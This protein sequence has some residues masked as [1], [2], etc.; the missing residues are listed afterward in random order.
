MYHKVFGEVRS[1]LQPHLRCDGR[2]GLRIC[3][4]DA[5]PVSASSV[6]AGLKHYS[7]D[8]ATT[9]VIEHN[10]RWAAG[11]VNKP[12]FQFAYLMLPTLCNQACRGCF[13][14]QD[15]HLLPDR[16]KGPYFGPEE[17]QS[18]VDFLRQHGAKALVYGGGGELFTWAGAFDLV[19]HVAACGLAMVIFTNG[20]LLT[21]QTIER[22]NE[23][24]VSII[25]SLRDTVET[26]HNTAVGRSHFRA[27]LQTIDDALAVGFQ[28]DSRLAVEIPVTTDNEDRVIDDF[29][30]VMRS[31]GVVPMIEEYIQLT[32]SSEEQRWCHNFA[33]S[34]R[35]FER[36]CAKDRSLGVCWEPEYGQRMVAQPRCQR[37]LYSFAVFPSRDVVDC[38]SHTVCYGNLRQTTLRDIVYSDKFRQSLLHYRL[39]PCSVFYTGTHS[40][41]PPTLP[42]QLQVFV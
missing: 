28:R 4:A 31:L 32:T 2:L 35:F 20:A 24:D 14:G 5:V 18:F 23:L 8:K 17:I 39:C 40:E 25:V 12:Q 26:Y 19:E 11:Q 1:S 38:P 36:A 3:G 9:A 30:P 7:A 15:K 33:Q 22:L 34:R 27:T 42:Q 10:L 41:I 29:L 16:L 37:P 13:M 21:R 6:P